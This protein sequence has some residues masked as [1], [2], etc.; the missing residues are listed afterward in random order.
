MVD[1]TFP[2]LHL[3]MTIPDRVYRAYLYS[4]CVTFIWLGAGILTESDQGITTIVSSAHEMRVGGC[5]YVLMFIVALWAVHHL[6]R[7]S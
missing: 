2:R 5:V 3:V 7:E 6:G 4:F 1:Q